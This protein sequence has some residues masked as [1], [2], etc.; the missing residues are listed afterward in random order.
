MIEDR[1][2]ALIRE[3][4][5]AAAIALGIDGELPE[6]E[7]LAPKQK[8]HGDF[9]TNVALALASRAGRPPREVAEAIVR[10]SP[11]RRS[12]R[13]V[14]VAGPG[15][16]N[17]FLTPDWLHDALREIDRARGP[18]TAG[19]SRTGSA[20]RWSSSVANP[21]GP[22]HVGHAR[23]AAIGDALAR[24]LE[25]PGWSVER[26]YY[27]NDAGGQMDRFG[28]SVEARYLQLLGRDAE[29]PED[30]YRGDYVTD[31]AQD[32]LR[33]R[34]R[35]ARRPARRRA[36]RAAARRRRG[37]RPRRDPGD[38]RAVRRALRRLRLRA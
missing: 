10:R 5:G 1:L 17:L 37:A 28:A 27:F 8:D 36:A 23:N 21:T 30:G 22:L 12:S 31:I 4:L 18:T 35:R 32:I 11:K 34:G 38:A 25:P 16:I 6:P 19:R 24:L 29:V 33:D 14:E 15:F 2:L 26:E 7:L 9:A 13:S 3:A 20:C